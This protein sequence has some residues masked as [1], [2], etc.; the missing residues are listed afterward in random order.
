MGHPDFSQEID[1]LQ[2]SLQKLRA[3]LQ[4]PDQMKRELLQICSG[5][6]VILEKIT[7]DEVHTPETNPSQFTNEKEELV[8]TIGMVLKALERS[9]TELRTSEAHMRELSALQTATAALLKTIDLETLLGQILDAAT[10]AIPA[11]EKGMLH[12]IARDTGQLEMRATIGYSDPRIRKFSFPGSKGYVAKAVREHKP[13]LIDDL[14]S[15]PAF[16]YNG[17]IQEAKAIRSVIV[18]P[19]VL[20]DAVLGAL[21]LDSSLP[22]AFTQT[23]LQLLASFAATATTAIQN[24]QLHSEVQKLATTDALTGIY[25]RRGLME[26]GRREVDRAQRFKRPLS[27]IFFDIDHFKIVNDTYGHPVGDQVLRLMVECCSKNIREVDLFGRYGGE[28][29]IVLL[30]ETDAFTAYKVAERLRKAVEQLRV[31]SP[32]GVISITISLG[33][34][35]VTPDIRDMAMLVQN[36]DQALYTAKQKGRNRTEILIPTDPK[37]AALPS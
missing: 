25:N 14:V 33:I 9:Q 36:A 6:L 7:G 10:T 15:E 37:S 17:S 35:R 24:A 11:A 12:L 20:E 23:D 13:L 32:E 31:S 30:P 8:D 2:D 19:L 26:F 5:I 3:N 28:E 22:K 4:A 34:A 27:A 1:E 21:S 29:F 18:A 16:R